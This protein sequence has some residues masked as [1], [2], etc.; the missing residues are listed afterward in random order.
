MSFADSIPGNLQKIRRAAVKATKA[1]ADAV[2]FPD[3]ATTGCAQRFLD[4][5]LQRCRL[6]GIPLA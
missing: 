6:G 3:C 4:S 5:I 2:L 1:G